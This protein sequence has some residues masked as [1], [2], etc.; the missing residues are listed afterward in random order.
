M[1]SCI[2]NSN[3]YLLYF[4]LCCKNIDL[5]TCSIYKKY[6][7]KREIIHK[8]GLLLFDMQRGECSRG[9]SHSISKHVSHGAS[10]LAIFKEI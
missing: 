9:V 8:Y 1:K 5:K 7:K 10:Y 2:I 3:R 4:V 6:N